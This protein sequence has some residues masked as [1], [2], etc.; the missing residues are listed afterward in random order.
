M[1]NE[2]YLPRVVA[3]ITH[4]RLPD[5]LSR[6]ARIVE[7]VIPDYYGRARIEIVETTVSK[8]LDAGHALEARE[9]VDVIICSGATSEYL[10]RHISTAIL[11]I[12]MGEY[13]LIRALDLARARTTKVGIVSFQQ[14]HP[15]LQAM[16]SLFTV[17]IRQVTYSSYEGARQQVHRLVDDG[18]RVVV[19][20]STAV[21]I[22]EAAGAQGILALNA[23]TVRRALED[24]LAICR[25]R[26]QSLVQQQR[27]NAV[28]RNLSDGVIAVDAEGTVQSLNP[29]MA[30]LLDISGDWARGRPL[31]EVVPGLDFGNVHFSDDAEESRILKIGG[32]TLVVNV[33][34]IIE[35]GRPDGLVITCQETNAIQRAERRIRS[36]V[37]PRQFTARYRFEQMLGEAPGFRVMLDLAQ[38]YANADA[39]VLVHG[40]SGTG[41]ELLAQSMHNASPRQAGPFVAINCAAFPESLLES[42]LFGHEEGAFTGSRKGGKAGLIEN[43]H[44]GT[45]FLDEI[46]DMPVTLQTRL[47]R[48]LQERE[49]LRLG[50]A[51]PTPVDIRVIAAT[52]RDLRARVREG[53][54][55]ED[56]YYRLNILRLAIPPLRERPEDIP[57]LAQSLLARLSPRTPTSAAAHALLDRLM[58]YLQRHGWPGNIRELEN[59]VERAVLS[60]NVLQDSNATLALQTLFGEL[61]E[62]SPAL[63]PEALGAHPA[64]DLRSLSRA[65]E[66][67]RVSEMVALCAGDMDEAARR[68]GISRT[69]LW[70]RLRSTTA[71]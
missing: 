67:A 3:L 54:F 57:M 41:K 5:G 44:T 71:G 43:A 36:Q 8:L 27:L 63:S 23:D 32:R 21:E 19:G 4:L 58:P 46:G 48:V 26:Q 66:S 11:S 15:E 16:S 56:L 12:R 50:A 29:R 55:R 38:R 20:S 68:L 62:A 49:V 61:F 18:Y 1:H 22:A 60:A 13:D 10:R 35:N 25:S 52:H 47:L 17:D 14:A 42:E 28:L 7:Q 34:P 39:T 33:T 37:K 9:D 51:E 6:M 2:D 31:N 69:T 64:Q 65:Q 45:L 24:A 70:R 30:T 40:E 59:I 53:E